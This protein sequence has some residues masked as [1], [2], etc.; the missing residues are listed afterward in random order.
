MRSRR[1]C[2]TCGSRSSSLGWRMTGLLS[3][4]PQ[5]ISVA[6][7]V[8]ETS[9][10]GWAGRRRGPV[11]KTP[12]T[13]E[14]CELSY[15]FIYHRFRLV[16]F[17]AYFIIFLSSNFL[18]FIYFRCQTKMQWFSHYWLIMSKLFLSWTAEV[19]RQSVIDER[20]AFV[21]SQGRCLRPAVPTWKPRWSSFSAGR[22]ITPQQT[23]APSAN[24]RNQSTGPTPTTNTFTCYF[25]ICPP[26]SR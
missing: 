16:L 15:R 14:Q 22:R 20:S 17:L 4:G 21:L 12:V 11:R 3:S 18:S 2:S 23:W 6:A 26:C 24:T 25:K 9:G 7:S 19:H 1:C 13:R 10:L 8:T 5:R